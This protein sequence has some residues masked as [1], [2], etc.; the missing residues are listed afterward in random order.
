MWINSR[1]LNQMEYVVVPNVYHVL[2]CID[3]SDH[4][5]LIR[6]KLFLIKDTILEKHYSVKT[7]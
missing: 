7:K 5:F 6:I 3:G 4:P 2:L 1:G